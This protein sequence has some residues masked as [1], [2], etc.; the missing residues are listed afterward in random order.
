MCPPGRQNCDRKLE[1]IKRLNGD[2]PSWE[3]GG[4]V[5]E[6]RKEGGLQTTYWCAKEDQGKEMQ[7][8]KLPAGENVSKIHSIF[9]IGGL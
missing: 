7:E 8:A 4:R 3:R 2:L 9:K 5:A 6:R 1:G